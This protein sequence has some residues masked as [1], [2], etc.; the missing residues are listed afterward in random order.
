MILNENPLLGSG[1]CAVCLK[2]TKSCTCL[3][4]SI[5]KA[6]KHFKNIKS[7]KMKKDQKLTPKYWIGHDPKTDDV[8]ISSAAK[9]YKTCESKFKHNVWGGDE[10]S[11]YLALSEGNIGIKLFSIDFANDGVGQTEDIIFE[12]QP[13]SWLK[14]QCSKD[15]KDNSGT[16][17]FKKGNTYIFAHSSGEDYVTIDDQGIEHYLGADH[18]RAHFISVY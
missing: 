3:E 18:L 6:V 5:K 14:L 13:K 12:S 7:K 8:Y 15:F 16:V 9:D 4:D 11:F 1:Y 2:T 17:C 10:D